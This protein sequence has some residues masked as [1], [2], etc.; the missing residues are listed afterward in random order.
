[1]P[2]SSD[3]YKSIERLLTGFDRVIMLTEACVAK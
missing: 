2:V 1:M 3:C